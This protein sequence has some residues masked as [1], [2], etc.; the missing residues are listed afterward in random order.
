MEE[1]F[2]N[3]K[4]IKN[5]FYSIAVG[6]IT[7][8]VNG[9]FGGGGGMVVVPMLN[10]FLKYEKKVSHATAILIILPISTISALIYVSTG[11]FD[12]AA[13]F[14]VLLGALFGGALGAIGLYKLSNKVVALIFAALMLVSGVKM[15]FF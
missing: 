6:F 9:L 4:G 5:R 12:F 2:T 13:T 1:V 15:G 10:G 7:G 8:A 3:N 14:P 11:S